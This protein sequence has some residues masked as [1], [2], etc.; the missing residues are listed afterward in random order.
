VFT[1]A[2]AA[3]AASAPRLSAVTFSAV[4]KKPISP[5]NNIDFL[6]SLVT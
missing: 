3:A 1:S 2:A 6:F 4:L 5:A